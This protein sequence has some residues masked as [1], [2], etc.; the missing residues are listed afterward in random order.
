MS[1]HAISLAINFK[2][3]QQVMATLS[4]L[5]GLLKHNPVITSIHN[6][7]INFLY[8]LTMIVGHYLAPDFI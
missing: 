2:V 7:M 4:E 8:T 6:N 1:T 5:S 3:T